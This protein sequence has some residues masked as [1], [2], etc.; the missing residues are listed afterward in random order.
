MDREAFSLTRCSMEREDGDTQ[1]TDNALY[2]W[3]V[4]VHEELKQS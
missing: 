1:M 2:T 4:F 3:S